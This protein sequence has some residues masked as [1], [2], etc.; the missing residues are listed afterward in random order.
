MAPKWQFVIEI[1][2]SKYKLGDGAETIV[3]S[4]K[5]KVIKVGEGWVDLESVLLD[6]CQ[7]VK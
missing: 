6:N 1:K 4:H 2:G 5:I 3:L 7:I